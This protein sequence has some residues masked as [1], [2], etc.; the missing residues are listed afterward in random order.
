MSHIVIVI[1]AVFPHFKN[2]SKQLHEMF[3]K[4]VFAFVSCISGWCSCRSSPLGM[5]VNVAKNVAVSPGQAN[6]YE[7]LAW[8]NDTLQ[9]SFT[10]LEQVYT[11]KS[12]VCFYHHNQCQE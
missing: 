4:S 12:F 7:L 2:V 9:T 1:P 10:R 6:S 5:E 8:L 11:G 3:S